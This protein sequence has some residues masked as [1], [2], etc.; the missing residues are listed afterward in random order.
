MRLKF[1]ILPKLLYNINVTLTMLFFERRLSMS[2]VDD[3]LRPGKR[4]NGFYLKSGLL[5]TGDYEEEIKRL[6]PMVFFNEKDETSGKHVGHLVNTK[7][8]LNRTGLF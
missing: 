1:D 2:Y 8:L 7:E 3:E 6:P 4:E 5:L